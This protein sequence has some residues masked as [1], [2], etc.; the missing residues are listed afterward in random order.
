MKRHRIFP[1]IKLSTQVGRGKCVANAT[2]SGAGKTCMFG[3][4][5]MGCSVMSNV[6]ITVKL[7]LEEVGIN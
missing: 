3:N 7:S 2:R 4:F 5:Y 6:H 1:C